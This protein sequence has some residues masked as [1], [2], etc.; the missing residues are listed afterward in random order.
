MKPTIRR[1]LW[2]MLLTWVLV[3]NEVRAG[4]VIAP[5]AQQVAEND[6]YWDFVPDPDIQDEATYQANLVFQELRG[7]YYRITGKLQSWIMAFW[8]LDDLD[9][10]LQKQVQ[11]WGG[12]C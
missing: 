3:G 10:S 12:G 1:A 4:D 6:W 5:Q 2:A 7:S 9:S 11:V 8:H